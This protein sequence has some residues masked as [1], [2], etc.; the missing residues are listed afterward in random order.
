MEQPLLREILDSHFL[1]S[2]PDSTL[3]TDDFAAFI[4]ERKARLRKEI[5]SATSLHN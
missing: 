3:R 5:E 1:P 4:E 2:A